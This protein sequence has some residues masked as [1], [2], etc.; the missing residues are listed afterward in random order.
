MIHKRFFRTES[1]LQRRRF[2][3]E[4]AVAATAV[5]SFLI[6]FAYHLLSLLVCVC[7]CV[8][9]MEVRHSVCNELS[10]Y[11]NQFSQHTIYSLPCMFTSRKWAQS[12]ESH[13]FDIHR[14]FSGFHSTSGIRFDSH[15]H[16]LCLLEIS[17]CIG[18]LMERVRLQ[19]REEK[20]NHFRI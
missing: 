19:S 16:K 8:A 14:F 20:K 5:I 4:A 11:I 2:V 1:G 9:L 12:N 3:A 7:G 10:A 18:K 17:I 13:P 15:R 6:L